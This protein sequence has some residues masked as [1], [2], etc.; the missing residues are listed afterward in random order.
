MQAPCC[1][2][3]S[4]VSEACNRSCLQRVECCQQRAEAC[5]KLSSV[6]MLHAAE[7]SRLYV[8]NA[9]SYHLVYHRYTK[10]GLSCCASLYPDEV[11][12]CKLQLA[13][14]AVVYC[15]CNDVRAVRMTACQAWGCTDRL[16]GLLTLTEAQAC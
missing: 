1:G 11:A 9:M 15:H 5:N 2:E 12:T 7:R 16:P 4:V 8:C 13:Q 6:C 10:D 3:Q 14:L